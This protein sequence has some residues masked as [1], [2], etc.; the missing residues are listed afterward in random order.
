VTLSSV[1]ERRPTADRLP[2]S[3]YLAI[4]LFGIGTGLYVLPPDPYFFDI[5]HR[6]L[7]PNSAAE[8]R[9]ELEKKK[10]KVWKPKPDKL[11]SVLGSYAILWWTA[12][13]LLRWAGFPVSRRIVSHV[14]GL[15]SRWAGLMFVQANLPYVVWIAAFNTSFLFA[16]LLVHMWASSN[17][18][19]QSS[20][21]PAI[22]EAFNRN[23]LV[24]FLVVRVLSLLVCH[25]ADVVLSGQ[26]NLLTGL[27][28]VSIESM[29][30]SDSVAMVALLLYCGGV[31]GVAWALRT[32]RL[33]L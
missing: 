27:V 21:A 5:L 17:P 4:F 16:Y 33:R 25:D 13:A 8:T 18:T 32:K 29:Y 3:G 19:S 9:R 6:K 23:G 30:A 11:A 2:L 31:V 10:Q 20:A 28:N 26:A 24:V 1:L 15:S 7:S 12:Y 14:L 22:F